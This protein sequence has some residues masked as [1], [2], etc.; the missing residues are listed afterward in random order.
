MIYQELYE[1][2]IKHLSSTEIDVCLFSLTKLDWDNNVHASLDDFAENVGTTKKYMR[3]V[4]KRL[5]YHPDKKIFEFRKNDSAGASLKF[6]PYRNPINFNP[7]VDRYSKKY[8]FFY[9]DAFKKLSLNAKR[10]MII[11]A[12]EMSVTK[13]ETFNIEKTRFYVN[14]E[15]ASKL[16]ISKRQLSK[17]IAEINKRLKNTVSIST[18][19]NIYTRKEELR[20]EFKKG[21]LS[22]YV[23]NNTE[24][25]LLRKKIYL[26]GV[27]IPIQEFVCVGIEKVGKSLFRALLSEEKA[28][29][30]NFSF[31][32]DRR[33]DICELARSIYDDSIKRFS[34]VY[35]SLS[36]KLDETDKVSAYFSSIVHDVISEYLAKTAN[37]VA[38]IQ[39][40]L[41]DIYNN[42]SLKGNNI[43]IN[44]YAEIIKKKRKHESIEH[45]LIWVSE[46]WVESRMEANY[47]KSKQQK[48]NF[49][50]VMEY[51]ENII[52][53]EKARIE[54]IISRIEQLKIKHI[55][56][57][58]DT[59]DFYFNKLLHKKSRVFSSL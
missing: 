10:M 43:N 26:N 38:M 33:K 6:L 54:K 32:E 53:K 28:Y 49:A 7:Y 44:K 16:P 34:Q 45:I 31:D 59:F 15:K 48:K 41:Q 58:K 50:S 55:D 56:S 36:K 30:K 20:F 47:K 18:V 29:S 52:N 5:T 22:E 25:F 27:Q 37:Q 12:F 13:R 51:S 42:E 24:R 1:H 4:L 9:T 14:K 40:L 21:T 17:V 46:K 57:I 23:K 2:M 8:N 11:A 3:E 19:S 35:P 39:D